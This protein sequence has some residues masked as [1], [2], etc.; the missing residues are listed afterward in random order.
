[1]S[2]GL[3]SE[4]SIDNYE[5]LLRKSNYYLYYPFNEDNIIEIPF[6]KKYSFYVYSPLSDKNGYT[7]IINTEQEEIEYYY[8]NTEVLNE[9]TINIKQL[10]QN[11]IKTKKKNDGNN[12]FSLK[13]KDDSNKIIIMKINIDNPIYFKIIRSINDSDENEQNNL[14]ENQKS[15]T[16]LIIIII[17]II[18]ILLTSFVGVIIYKIKKNK[19]KHLNINNLDIMYDEIDDN[20]VTPYKE[21]I[22]PINDENNSI[23][24]FK[25][26][27]E[28]SKS[29]NLE[30]NDESV[31]IAALPIF[32]NF[33]K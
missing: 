8:L 17:L 25:C 5:I 22:N 9:N 13:K 23:E 15:N 12:L 4:S 32:Y 14:D 30:N 29:G 28:K 18:F 10:E 26:S 19:N 21:D 33:K 11:K 20:S 6:I 16:F 1:M 3:S 31:E 7:F 24:L 27:H 2:F